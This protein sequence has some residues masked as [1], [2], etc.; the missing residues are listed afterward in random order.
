MKKFMVIDCCER[1]IGEP[2]HGLRLTIT[3][4]GMV[5]SSKLTSNR[6]LT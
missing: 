1:E 4:T 3:I 2:V 6:F 5:K